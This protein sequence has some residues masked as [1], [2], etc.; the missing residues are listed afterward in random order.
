[1]DQSGIAD[2]AKKAQIDFI[3][4][5]DR[6]QAG[7]SD[8]GIAGFSNDILF[9]TGGAFDVDGSRIIGVNLHEPLKPNLAPNDLISVAQ[10][11]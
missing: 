2:L 4:L 8:F 11:V 3:F 6:V 9:I 10:Q 7:D 1:M 5:A